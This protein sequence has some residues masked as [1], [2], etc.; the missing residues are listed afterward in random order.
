VI[1]IKQLKISLE[2]A[3]KA[4]KNKII[5]KTKNMFEKP[6]PEKKIKSNNAEKGKQDQ[7]TLMNSFQN[8]NNSCRYDAFLAFFLYSLYNSDD[9]LFCL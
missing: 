5:G 8:N 9:L 7:K 2:I 6:K 4:K 3:L 1:P